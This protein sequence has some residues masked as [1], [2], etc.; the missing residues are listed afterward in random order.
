MTTTPSPEPHKQHDT[1]PAP[2]TVGPGFE[3]QV[4]QFWE[5]NRRQ[6]VFFCAA[7]LLAIVAKEAWRYFSAMRE[8]DLGEEYARVVASPTKLAAFAGEHSRHPLGA[9]AC[10]TLA[11]QKYLGGDYQEAATLYQKAAA[12]LANPALLGRARLGEAVSRLNAGDQAAGVAALKALS[13]D[14][15]LLKA[16][17]S[18][19]AY[20]LASLAAEAGKADEARKLVEEVSK[21]DPASV[22]TQRAT[23]LLASLPPAEKKPD[24]ASPTPP[25][26]FKPGG[27]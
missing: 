22:W 3:E 18:E 25:I 12:S 11:D 9:A 13:A 24:A 14:A 8:R 17:R 1:P 7:I 27:K 23:V 16:T 20:H 21:I 15:A 2:A 5:K 4:R 10:L 19:A 26:T 6:V